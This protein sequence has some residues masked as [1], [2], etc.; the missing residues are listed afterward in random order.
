MSPYRVLVK[1]RSTRQEFI[2][3]SM[4]SIDP[5]TKERRIFI[6]DKQITI[7]AD[8][9]DIKRIAHKMT[10]HINST[11]LQKYIIVNNEATNRYE[12]YKCNYDDVE[13]RLYNSEFTQSDCLIAAMNDFC[14]KGGYVI[15]DTL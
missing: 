2:L 9:T 5:K 13:Y 15:I 10:S 8:Y 14:Q 7:G 6:I 1:D 3:A 12:V 11:I 4:L